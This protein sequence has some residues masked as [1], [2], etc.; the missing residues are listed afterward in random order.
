MEWERCNILDGSGDVP[1]KLPKPIGKSTFVCFGNL[2]ENQ[3]EKLARWLISRTVVVRERPKDGGRPDLKSMYEVFR[4]FK[5]KVVIWNEIMIHFGFPKLTTNN[6]RP[7]KD[8]EWHALKVKH[9]M[10]KMFF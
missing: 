7:Y 5:R 4:T 2:K 9:K 10:D 1:T 6:Q 3:P 8:E